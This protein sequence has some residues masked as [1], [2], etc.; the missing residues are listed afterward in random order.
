MRF[1][2]IAVITVI[3]CKLSLSG[4]S[5]SSPVT[6]QS[7]L[8]IIG[9]DTATVADL[10]ETWNAIDE[11]SREIFTASEYPAGDYIDAYTR[12]MMLQRELESNDILI[13][14]EIISQG[15]SW[16]R[17]MI[18]EIALEYFY[19][20]ALSSV[21]E[22]DLQF[23]RDHMGKTVWF[24]LYPGTDTASFHGPDHLPELDFDFAVLLDSLSVL[25]TGNTED[26]VTVRLDSVYVTDPSL[27]AET[28]ADTLFCNSMARSRIARGR[29]RR[30]MNGVRE[31]LIVD[32]S[33]VVD[34]AAVERLADYYSGESVL[35]SE[36]VLTSSLGDWTSFQLRDEINFQQSR[37]HVQP[38]SPTWQFFFIDNLSMNA[39]LKEALQHEAQWLLDSL[40]IEVEA[41]INELALDKLYDIMVSSVV[42]IEE[43]DIESQYL[44]LEEPLMIEE[45]RSL[46]TV[47]IPDDRLEEYRAA[48]VENGKNEFISSLQ[49]FVQLAADSSMPQ[50]TF[51]LPKRSV[52]GGFGEVVF[53]I[54]PSDTN[55]WLGPFV[56]TEGSGQVMFRLVEVLPER[57]ATLDESRSI[58]ESMIR[59]R[60]EE[61]ATIEWMQYLELRY[62]PCL[63]EDVLKSL[64]ADPGSWATL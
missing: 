37:I 58:L 39:F 19:S 31:N 45:M 40:N 11:I 52:P 55:S 49:G 44:S 64:P 63:N 46:Q 5:G 48:V 16:Q 12:N 3:V 7:W 2:T 61:E 42:T 28:I 60:L 8:I 6:G 26:G 29:N 1:V 9:N 22:S 14:T 33:I 24:T 56:L 4:C 38:L 21:T 32:Y 25:D 27:V 13:S 36:T 43:S 30:W 57:E 23:Y 59:I 47:I 50:I 35:I 51:P 41:Y 20:E 54:D 17:M 10:G 53:Q 15:A 18:T 62:E 34:S